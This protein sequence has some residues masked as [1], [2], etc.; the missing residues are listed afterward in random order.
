MHTQPSNV[1]QL[2]GEASFGF[3]P[4][5]AFGAAPTKWLTRG[6]IPLG[7]ITVLA[8]DPGLGKTT[9]CTFLAGAVSRGQISGDTAG[10]PEDVLFVSVED[11]VQST[12]V[13]R[14]KAVDAN[15][16]RVHVLHRIN[17]IQTHFTIPDGIEEL[18]E[19]VEI[20]RP[21]LLVLDPIVALFSPNVNVE[22]NQDVRR[23]L[24]PLVRLAEDFDLAV[25]AINHLTKM[26]SL[27]LL[28]R[29][30]GSG[31]LVAASRS[32][33]FFGRD[34]ADPMGQTRILSHEKC[35]VGALSETQRFKITH[36]EEGSRMIFD[37]ASP[38]KAM[39]SLDLGSSPQEV[40]KRQL[41][42]HFLEEEL[43]LGERPAKALRAIAATLGLT[44]R[45]LSFARKKTGAIYRRDI[46]TGNWMLRLP[47][48]EQSEGVE[49]S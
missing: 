41:A 13:P 9:Y 36:D 4:L 28:K 15:L 2:R 11:S 5:E 46:T 10:R 48:E 40:E 1:H 47:D 25:V 26:D 8:G 38:F 42:I 43:M 49:S 16:A 39:D 24:V 34:P 44:E 14:M 3:S 20:M 31:A 19:K 7:A 45:E 32:V 12:I 37:G 21:K 18:R 17:G 30:A 6:R 27:D 22:K 33:L 29:V 23:A 35:N